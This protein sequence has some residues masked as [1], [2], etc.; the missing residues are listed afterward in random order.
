MRA[1]RSIPREGTAIEAH[2][3][4][5]NESWEGTAEGPREDPARARRRAR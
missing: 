3:G 5:V 1:P 4:A 2:E